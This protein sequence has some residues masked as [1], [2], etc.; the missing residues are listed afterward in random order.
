LSL[1]L[2][3]VAREIVKRHLTTLT[4]QKILN[5]EQTMKTVDRDGI[6][7][8]AIECG[9]NQGGSAVL[10]ALLAKPE[11]RFFGYGAASEMD[12]V[13]S[14]F[15]ALGVDVD[16]RVVALR[17]LVPRKPPDIE[18]KRSVA[19]AHINCDWQTSARHCLDAMGARLSSGGF[20]MLDD[21]NQPERC[22]E[23]VGR[24]LAEH[25]GFSLVGAKS[26]T[27]ITRNE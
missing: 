8:D 19:L 17:T 10:L 5:L 9:L 3:P 7:G 18:P 4:P 11:R 2:S 13:L 25:R 14:T 15:R 16:G 22:T 20:L 6:P 12:A 27:V 24:F 21:H 26:H 23:T 1:S